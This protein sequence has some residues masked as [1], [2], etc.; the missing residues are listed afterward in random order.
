MINATELKNGTTFLMNGDPYRVLKYKHQKIARGGGTIKLNLI[1]LKT[2]EKKEKTMNSSVKV[3]EIETVKRPLT[4]LYKQDDN[5]VFMNQR[6]F[7]QV[8]IPLGVIGEQAAFIKEGEDVDVLFWSGKPLSVDIPP[9]VTLEVV[10]T[11]PGAKGDSATNI[12]KPAKLENDISL[13]VPLFVKKGDKISVDT[14][15]KEY[16][17]RAR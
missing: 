6:T 1:N 17:E 2:G 7:E 10:D 16:I 3:D 8:E 12:Y 15:T 11:A 9:K 5:A 4:F 13:K 14:K